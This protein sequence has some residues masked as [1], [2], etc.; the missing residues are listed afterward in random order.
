MR[1]VAQIQDVL[2]RDPYPNCVFHVVVESKKESGIL[3][4]EPGLTS[5][6]QPGENLVMFGMEREPLQCLMT[7]GD[8]YLLLLDRIQLPMKLE[9]KEVV[10]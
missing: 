3:H 4:I 8:L 2:V 10:L 7:L 1:R 6:N 9:T 5:R